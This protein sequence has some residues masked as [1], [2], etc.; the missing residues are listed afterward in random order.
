MVE[1]CSCLIHFF[2]ADNISLCCYL[3]FPSNIYS[4]PAPHLYFADFRRILVIG[5]DSFIY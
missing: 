5:K 3:N 4:L 1:T 2:L